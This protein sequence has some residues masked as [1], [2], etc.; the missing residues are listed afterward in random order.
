MAENDDN[1]V[2]LDLDMLLHFGGKIIHMA[3]CA[4]NSWK[5][6]NPEAALIYF[7]RMD[8]EMGRAFKKI[9]KENPE[10]AAELLAAAQ[11]AN[12]GK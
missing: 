12:E 11:N 6:G 4:R 1:T 9:Q 5:A 2:E 8:N 3:G 10:L 7:D